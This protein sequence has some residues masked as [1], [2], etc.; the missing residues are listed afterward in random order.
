MADETKRT[1]PQLTTA[2]RTTASDLFEIASPNTAMESGY[3]S[4]K[5]SASEVANLVNKNLQYSDLNSSDKHIVGAINEVLAK[6]DDLELFKFP[7]AT[8]VGSPTINNGQI[9]DFSQ[10]S[11]LRFPFL[12]DFQ[13]RHFAINMEFTTAA[14]VTNQQNIFDS[15]FGLAFA[16]RSAKFVIAV[17][18]NGTSWNIGEGV[19]S[20]T[21]LP[22]TTYRVQLAWDGTAYKLAYSVNGGES[23]TEDISLA[24]TESPFPK[25]VY[26]GVGENYASVLNFFKGIINLNYAS[27]Y[28]ADSLV[29]QG[30]DDVGLA[31]RLATDL[32]NIDAAGEQRI[33]DIAGS[34]GGGSNVTMAANPAGGVDL[35][36]ENQKQTLAKQEDLAA[37]LAEIRE[38]PKDIKINGNSILDDN[39][40]ANIPIAGTNASRL[41]VVYSKQSNLSG[42]GIQA[43]GNLYLRKA[44]DADIDNRSRY[45][46]II[47][48]NLDYAVKVA[49]CDGKGAEW[50]DEEKTMA[51]HRIG[52]GDTNR[53]LD[54]LWKLNK[55]QTYD[56]LEKVETGLATHP[57]GEFSKSLIDIRGS[58]IQDG[59]PSPTNPV[60]IVS[61]EQIN[62]SVNGIVRT[63]IPPFP[64]NKIGDYFDKADIDSG[65]WINNIVN[66]VIQCSRNNY[67]TA[68]GYRYLSAVNS[69]LSNERLCLSPNYPYNPL[70]GMSGYSTPNLGIRVNP[71]NNQKRLILE[72]ESTQS[73]VDVPLWYIS[74]NPTEE[75]INSSDLDYLKSLTNL[76]KSVN[77]AITDQDGNDISYLME[78]IIKLNEVN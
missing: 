14:D 18:S 33:K 34:G 20:H 7:N 23:Y 6:V 61:V 10:T 15:D 66:E 70:C 59:E 57:S 75:P 65:K 51:Q 11:Y 48:Q 52:M 63:I 62:I 3:A 38:L 54:A 29:W 40:V 68:L 78:Y 73:K 26:I 24:S 56:F 28:V 9:S 71:D 60:D 5:V 4:R 36:V 31:S 27:L 2:E 32:S 43:D 50:T 42:I 45:D 35:T 72:V 39:K 22:N 49:M 25:Q 21:V 69:V 13:G 55:G 47:P 37:E 19:G 12:M 64:L 74:S 17:S 46:A 77:I 1:I 8:I 41:G 67:A 76:D 16:I 30:M 53:S 58:S 44:S